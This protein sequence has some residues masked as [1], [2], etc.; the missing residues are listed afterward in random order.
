ML[1]TINITK[2]L[3]ALFIF[4]IVITFKV[5][6]YLS[7]VLYSSIF[8]YYFYNYSISINDVLLVKKSEYFCKSTCL[9]TSK[10][11]IKS[12]CTYLLR[13]KQADI[14]AYKP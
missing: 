3:Y 13:E 5:T 6:R 10:E 9:E 7:L 12:K 4:M 1:I 8:H 2:Q 11:Q 14:N